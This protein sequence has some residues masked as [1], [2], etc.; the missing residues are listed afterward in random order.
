M[1]CKVISVGSVCRCSYVL[2]EHG[3]YRLLGRD[4]MELVFPGAE[5]GDQ[6]CTQT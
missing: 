2:R 6:G 4:S 5:M 1:K 3:T